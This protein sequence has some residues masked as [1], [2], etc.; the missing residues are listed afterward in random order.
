MPLRPETADTASE[1]VRPVSRE[2][3]HFYTRPVRGQE[4]AELSRI[5]L[6]R[7]SSYKGAPL[8][9]QSCD[10]TELPAS[11]HPLGSTRLVKPSTPLRKQTRASLG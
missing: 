11:G 9:D 6:L 4:R 3:F 1:G 8:L 10:R 2:F 7:V 5:V